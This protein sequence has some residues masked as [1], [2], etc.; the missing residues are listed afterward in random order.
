MDDPMIKRLTLFSFFSFRMLSFIFRLTENDVSRIIS[1]FREK[2]V[3]L[4]KNE[5]SLEASRRKLKRLAKQRPTLSSSEE[6][7]FEGY[8]KGKRKTILFFNEYY[9]IRDFEFGWGQKAFVEANCPVYNCFTTNV[10][11]MFGKGPSINCFT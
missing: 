8:N 10:R 1:E 2:E 4:A 9:Y 11:S 6:K 3:S 7:A 5:I